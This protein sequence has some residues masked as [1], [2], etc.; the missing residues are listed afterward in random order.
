NGMTTA[1][2]ELLVRRDLARDQVVSSL[3]AG[4]IAPDQIVEPV[5]RYREEQRIAEIFVIEAGSITGIEDPSDGTLAQYH[6]DNGA[7]Y[8]A[9][10]YRAVT[11]LELTA[12]SVAESLEISDA[13]VED[14]YRL[15]LDDFSLPER[16]V[17]EMLLYDSEDAAR[18]ARVRIEA[19][20]DFAAVAEATGAVNTGGTALGEVVRE[21]LSEEIAS[22]VF[23]MDTGAVSEPLESGF[24]WHVFRV[25]EVIPEG[26]RPLD[27][28]REPL[29]RAMALTRALDEVYELSNRIEDDLAGGSTLDSAAQA[30]GL[31]TKYIAAIDQSGRDTNGEPVSGIPSPDQFIPLVFSADIGIE[32]SPQEAPDGGYFLIRVDAKT[33][34]ALRPLET[35]REAVLADWMAEE[36]LRRAEARARAAFEKLKGGAAF[37]AVAGEYGAV[38]FRTEPFTRGGASPDASLSPYLIGRLFEFDIGG[39]DISGTPGG[40]GYALARL[41]DVRTA[42]VTADVVALAQIRDALAGAFIGDLLQQYQ[43][44]IQRRYPIT[45]NQGVF[46]SLVSNDAF[47]TGTGSASAPLG[48]SGTQLPQRP[49][50]GL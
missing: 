25:T 11:V 18:S 19:G 4:S 6:L 14:E 22:N 31:T 46:D 23:V 44:A 1:G 17:A 30:E 27:E 5:Y 50:G 2:F 35:V 33:E 15:R 7:R 21:D 45:I 49:V 43:N 13:Q 36:R 29:R 40:G 8:T 39:V 16:R 41:D 20:E 10:E 26:P 37:A 12:Q 38:P 48:G 3:L 24:G 32:S 34:P 9:P 28:I 47:L 42:D